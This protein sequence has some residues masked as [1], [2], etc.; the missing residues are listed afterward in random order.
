MFDLAI[1]GLVFSKTLAR[2]WVY[3]SDGRIALVSS[4]RR[5]PALSTIELEPSEFLLPS[6]TD[7]HVHLRDWKQASK[8][9]VA[10]GTMSA[11]AGGVTTVAE[12]PN[13][14]PRIDSAEMVSKRIDLLRNESY[15]DFA[16][17]AGVP[18]ETGEVRRLRGAGAFA[19]KFYPRDLKRIRELAR[20]IRDHGL[21]SVVHAEDPS[22]I[23]TGDEEDAE[24]RAV[25]SVL[26]GDLGDHTNLRFAHISTPSAVQAII[27]GKSSNLTIEAAPHHLFMTREVAES[28]IGR[29]NAV[30]P[31]L[32]SAANSRKMFGFLQRG[33][34]D[35]YATDHAPHTSSEKNSPKPAPGFPGLEFAF[36]LIL[37]KT[38]DIALSCR[39]FCE[40]PARYLGIRKGR[41]AA[42][43]LADLVVMRKRSWT[44]DP[45][46][47][48]SK[49]RITPF[50]GERLD[51]SVVRVLKVGELVFDNGKLRR[52]SV[53]LVTETSNG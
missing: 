13:T 24:S 9:T 15:V 36:P 27:S 19:V 49:G 53:R 52:T 30:R 7:L 18:N 23:D 42:G 5:G 32:R 34:L 29:A 44:I 10:T 39:V 38:S 43:H 51:Y 48:I 46:K 1:H 4:E 33:L 50:Q 37:T 17:H 21:M 45:G 35:F 16:L 28:R 8:E 11:L 47:F 22:L 20:P 2:R 12:M 41:I 6:A 31:P 25:N 14:E 26:E 3:V 40:N